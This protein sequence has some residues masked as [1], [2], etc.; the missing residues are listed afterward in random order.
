MNR[1]KYFLLF[2]FFIVSLQ[3][4]A[5]D[6]NPENPD[7]N[8]LSPDSLSNAQIDSS[9]LLVNYKESKTYTLGGF[10]VLGT[11]YLDKNV[12]RSITN[13]YVGQPIDIPGDDIAK[14][15]KNLWK[16]GLFSDMEFRL[17]GVKDDK[18][19]ITLSVVEKPRMSNF[20][21]KGI[22]KGHSEDIS[23]KI[24][25]LKGRPITESLKSNIYNEVAD[26]Y[27]EK[28][29]MNPK[30]NFVVRQDTFALNTA[31]VYINVDKGSKVK[32]SAI[33][34]EGVNEGDM[35]KVRK[36]M[37]ET[38]GKTYVKLIQPDDKNFFKGNR[39]KNTLYTLGNLNIGSVKDFLKERVHITLFKGTKFN[40]DKFEA[41]KK[42]LIEYYNTIGYRD[43]RIVFD[44]VKQVS[45][46]SVKIK[47][48]I[49]EGNK[50]YFRNITFKGNAKYSS[51]QLSRVL[52]IEKGDVFNTAL[53]Q[54]KISMDPNGADISSL[55]YDDGYLFFQADPNEIAVGKDSI[56]LEIR[57][58]E[59]PQATIKN[60][61]I[62]GNDKTNEHVIRR[63]LRT[64]PGQKFSRTDLIRSQREIANL[65]YFDP[66]AT[67]VVPIPNPEDG[68]V[69]IKYTVTEKSADQIELSAGWGG[70]Q[71]IIGT[72]GLSF[73]NFSLRNIPNKKAWSP[74]PTGDGQKLSIR[75]QSN[76][77]RYQTYNIS[78]TEP[79][80]GGKKPNALSLSAFRSRFQLIDGS[81][82][83]V[84]R[85]ITNGASI[86]LGT[87]LKWPDDFFIF[88]ASLNYQN[89]QLVNFSQRIFSDNATIENG[90]FNNINLRLSLSRNSIDQPLYPT[91]GSNFSLV[92][93]FTP[94]YSLFRK[95]GFYD[96][97]LAIEDKYKWVEYHKWRVTV[98]WFQALDKKN[99][100][101][102]RLAAKF[103]FIGYYDKKTGLSPFERF[104]VG[105]NGLPSNIVL[106]G[107][108]IISQRGYGIY[109]DQGGDAIFNKLTME[110]RYPFSL[111]P[112]ATIYGIAFAEAGN[113][114][115]SFSTYN[116]YRLNKTVGIGVRAFLPMF[117]LLG[118]D[119]GIRFDQP[120][121]DSDN[122]IQSAKG[123]F[124]YI[125]KNGMFTIILGFEPE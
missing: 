15:L 79:W 121:N 9:K 34:F 4:F 32:I 18:V 113:S 57:I 24:T 61:I 43:A 52:G 44:T 87:R 90:S 92:G 51:E 101:V 21:F 110:L 65:G 70:S 27:R 94:P 64:L 10:R 29:Y 55:Y 3:A 48:K 28:G 118:V 106:F 47:M 109:S 41:D 46:S 100:F 83:V 17:D 72:L 86:G 40:E 119:Y 19:F 37:K 74:L 7:F 117:G 53:L 114:W 77:K 38:K 124:D 20:F 104:Q 54:K 13:L 68:T 105:G 120:N 88:Q 84:G 5:Q 73:N 56:D 59:G 66:Q 16:Q 71:G 30:V 107:Q 35:A 36:A 99:K 11:Q 25:S 58:T 80:L 50:Y 98:D 23:K 93:Q 91:S 116:P 1:L 82:S 14:A 112:S 89:Y 75:M 111:N 122:R 85:Q 26:F 8:A 45:S 115:R 2:P 31:S 81:N 12:V 103:G 39:L 33:E 125:A 6:S 42:A 62:E 95:D 78:F 96:N 123:F 97:N 108:D 102:L 63:E 49:E 69:D 67:Q 22:K 60:V 76:G